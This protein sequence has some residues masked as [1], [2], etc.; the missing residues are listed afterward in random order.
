LFQESTLASFLDTQD[1]ARCRRV[2]LLLRTRFQK[3]R[4]RV[5]R[6][7]SA[8]SGRNRQTLARYPLT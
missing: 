6:N 3:R 4:S 8:V 1:A 7:H 5:G 2:D